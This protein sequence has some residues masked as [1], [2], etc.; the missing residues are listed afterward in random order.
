M[1]GEMF[2]HR[3]RGAALAVAVFAQW[4]ANRV[5]TVSFRV[6]LSSP[7]SAAAYGI[8]RVSDERRKAVTACWRRL[9]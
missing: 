6:R 4:R 1:E 3:I 7:G 5:V 9:R 2:S 8:C